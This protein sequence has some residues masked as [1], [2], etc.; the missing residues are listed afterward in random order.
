M[1]LDPS[2]KGEI[3]SDTTEVL[4]IQP[5]R[6]RPEIFRQPDVPVFHKVPRSDG[7]ETDMFAFGRFFEGKTERLIFRG[8]ELE[9]IDGEIGIPTKVITRK[10]LEEIEAVARREKLEADLAYIANAQLVG[11]PSNNLEN[12]RD[13]HLREIFQPIIRPDISKDRSDN[14]FAKA[15]QTLGE[16]RKAQSEYDRFVNEKTKRLS[17][18]ELELV[19]KIDDELA[20]ILTKHLGE[21]TTDQA[22]DA[23]R[24]QT[25][26]R[27]DIGSYLLGKLNK[28]AADHPEEM[29]YR[30][31]ENVEKAS[32]NLYSLGKMTGRE[33]ATYLALAKID[34]SFNHDRQTK[35]DRIERDLVTKKVTHSQ[36][37]YAADYLLNYI[38]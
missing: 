5:T 2:T 36:H 38:I 15:Y 28:I 17:A 14:P 7:S 4:R 29:P 19:L 11:L 3:A 23:L 8:T 26:V 10:A 12:V 35:S 6:D 27:Y 33:Y 22:V 32:A 21:V 24:E 20:R 1:N 18:K 37:C 31:L 34:G 30:V 9:T 13:P 25:D 16:L